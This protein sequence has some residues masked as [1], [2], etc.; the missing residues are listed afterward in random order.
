MG[1]RKPRRPAGLGSEGARLW[2]EITSEMAKDGIV[3]TS[4]ERRWLEDACRTADAITDMEQA[5]DGQPRI[6]KGSQGQPVAHPLIGEIRQHRVTLSQLL[7]RV[8]M[9]AEDEASGSGSGSRTTSTQA[10]AA[11]LTRHYGRQGVG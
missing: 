11:A 5:L 1:V 3:P 6:V 7:A 10:R 8:K 9:F 2:V 4:Q